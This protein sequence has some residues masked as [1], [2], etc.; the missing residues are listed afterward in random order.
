MRFLGLTAAAIVAAMLLWVVWISAHIL[1]FR[2]H[3]PR[4]T[5]FMAQRIDEARH[6][7]LK[8]ALRYQWVP[9]ER[10]SPNL[11]RAMIASEDAKFSEHVGF[12][13]QAIRKAIDKNSRQG[14]IISGGSTITQQ[15]AKNLF[16]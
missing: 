13:W 3:P 9:Y 12:D 16:L 6:N 14:R 2:S 1:W 11:K 8:L 5:A 7:D 10:I 4:E 15:L